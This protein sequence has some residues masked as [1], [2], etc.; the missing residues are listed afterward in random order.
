MELKMCE[1]P[2]HHIIV[3]FGNG[4][5]SDAQSVAMFRMEKMLREM[6][7]PAEVFKETKADD[8][9]L[10]RNMTQEQRQNL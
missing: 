6:G 8:S 1:I 7:I 5:P 10:R 2:S 4:I 3:K 9:K